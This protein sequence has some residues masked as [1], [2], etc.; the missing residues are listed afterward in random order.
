MLHHLYSFRV[1]RTAFQIGWKLSRRFKNCLD[2]SRYSQNFPDNSKLSGSFR[3]ALK[4][5]LFRRFQTVRIQ[6][7]LMSTSICDCAHA[8]KR[9]C[10]IWGWGVIKIFWD[11]LMIYWTEWPIN[12]DDLLISDECLK[13]GATFILG[14]A[15]KKSFLGGGEGVWDS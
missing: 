6:A 8:H 1:F 15:S 11:L 2:V 14:K 10:D 13:T 9:Y 7:V 3:V 4:S 5:K 12:I